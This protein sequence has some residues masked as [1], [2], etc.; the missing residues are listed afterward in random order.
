MPKD[1][2]GRRN[3]VANAILKVRLA[4]G[5]DQREFS[6]VLGFSSAS[7]RKFEHNHKPSKR[8]LDRIISLAQSQGITTQVLD[9]YRATRFKPL[10]TGI[11]ALESVKLSD[12]EIG[13]IRGELA[14]FAKYYQ[15]AEP[16]IK[17]KAFPE[18]LRG[19]A[20]FNRIVKILQLGDKTV[21]VKRNR[22][23]R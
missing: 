19:M 15:T 7:L 2:S 8:F 9:E 16:D 6:K 14:S 11:S 13:Q 3:S 12:A 5:R 20:G 4:T 1:F 10:D 18:W 21:G 23:P 22:P 17:D